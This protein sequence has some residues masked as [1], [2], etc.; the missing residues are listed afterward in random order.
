M[1]IYARLVTKRNFGGIIFLTVV[2]ALLMFQVKVLRTDGISFVIAKQVSLGDVLLLHFRRLQFSAV[3][4]FRV[5]CLMVDVRNLLLFPDKHHSITDRVVSYTR[6]YMVYGTNLRFKSELYM[7]FKL[8]QFIRLYM[9]SRLFIEVD[10]PIISSMP[11][12][13][14]SAPFVAFHKALKKQVYLRISPELC[15]KRI[16]VSGF[17][18]IFEIGKSFRN[19]SLSV[20]HYSEFTSFEFY[21]V[22][23]NYFWGIAFLVDL[24]Q[25]LC[26]KLA[27][28]A[29]AVAIQINYFC[30]AGFDYLSLPE[31]IVK[32]TEYSMQQVLSV[33]FMISRLLKLGFN[34]DYFQMTL[35][36]LW[37]L[38]FE[39]YI[40]RY[41]VYPTFVLYFP[42]QDS[43]LAR[44]R[45]L[46]TAERYELYVA[47][48]E[49]ANGFTELNDAVEQQ[50]RLVEQSV[51][52]SKPLNTVFIDSLKFGMPSATGCG[53]GIDRLLMVIFSKSN[54]RDVIVFPEVRG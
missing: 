12:A 6:S 18:A 21:K 29:S 16:L 11:E 51:C 45:D 23:R 41:V 2:W 50:A 33:S 27:V 54:I 48:I 49:I 4:A 3:L 7:R 47:G 1:Y 43:P 38:Y 37:L 9:C 53:V 8:V 39:N 28:L 31:V 14:S 22:G 10:T 36:Q 42:I 35:V 30:S 26:L 17:D 44:S 15:L 34:Y 19:E 20:R 46:L 40:Q 5:L 32:Y 52:T 24:L 25:F 13:A